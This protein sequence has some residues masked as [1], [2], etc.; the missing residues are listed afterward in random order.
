MVDHPLRIDI[1]LPRLLLT[2]L[3]LAASLQ[4]VAN[5][6]A[7]ESTPLITLAPNLDDDNRDGRPDGED[8]E[9]NGESDRGDLA[10]ID[11]PFRVLRDSI[12]LDGPGA[13][14]FRVLAI[15]SHPREGSRVFVEC[16]RP[17]SSGSS[18]VLKLMEVGQGERERRYNL[19]NGLVIDEHFISPKPFGPVVDGVDILEESCRKA[20]Q[21]A[22]VVVHFLDAFEAYSRNAGEIHCGT[23]AIRQA[24]EH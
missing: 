17:R 15:E 9:I 3:L 24:P 1:N 23:N 13:G 8:E 4:P 10:C 12:M 11:V 19:V 21:E 6:V 7:A 16:I 2:V 22:G 18:A 14:C 20:L 5:T